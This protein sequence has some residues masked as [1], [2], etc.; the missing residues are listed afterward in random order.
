MQRLEELTSPPILLPGDS[1]VPSGPA[2]E[3]QRQRQILKLLRLR[4]WGSV[5]RFAAEKVVERRLLAWLTHVPATAPLLSS[6]EL[7]GVFCRST[8]PPLLPDEAIRHFAMRP[9]LQRLWIG[10]QEFQPLSSASPTVIRAIAAGG[11]YR[12]SSRVNASVTGASARGSPSQLA[13]SQRPF[14]HLH[15]LKIAFDTGESMA[16]L[17]PLLSTVTCLSVCVSY[18][19]NV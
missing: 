1:N 4:L 8:P 13:P 10:Q 14:E 18:M 7:D 15:Q 9:G 19:S 12:G 5:R 2:D 6:V 16:L 3:Q 17:A 11:G